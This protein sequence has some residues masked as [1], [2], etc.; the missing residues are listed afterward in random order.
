[1]VET[2]SDVQQNLNR[3]VVKTSFY[4]LRKPVE[5]TDLFEFFN[6]FRT[7]L[8]FQQNFFWLLA[9][10]FPIKLSKLLPTRS[11]S[12][13]GWKLFFLKNSFFVRLPNFERSCLWLS[14]KHLQWVCRNS[15]LRVQ[16]TN[17]RNRFFTN[18]LVF[19][20]IWTSSENFFDFW[21]F[22]FANL[23]KLLSLS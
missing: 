10:N 22:L 11:R 16:G 7:Y 9:E 6:V 12:T 2:F 20:Y 8:D 23:S 1:M 5:E 21:N 17:W 4:L 14:A 19:V 18:F 3:K 15:S 13:V